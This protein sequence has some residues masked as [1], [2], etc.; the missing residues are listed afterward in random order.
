MKLLDDIIEVAVD[1]SGLIGNLLRKCLDLEQQAKN[2]KFKVW[3]NQALD[4]YDNPDELPEYR[5]FNYVNRG[6]LISI[7]RE[8]NSQPLSLHVM[9]EQDRKLVD[10]VNR[11]KAA[12]PNNARPNAHNDTQLPR[13]P[14][15]KG[16]HQV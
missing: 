6:V 3:L 4:G 1:N 14:T 9:S 10:E 16:K 12:P 15:L 5:R 11:H 7:A 8:M 2:E 13:P